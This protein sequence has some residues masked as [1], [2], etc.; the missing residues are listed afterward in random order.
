MHKSFTNCTI[1]SVLLEL[2]IYFVGRTMYAWD[3]NWV[4][5]LAWSSVSYEAMLDV[6]EKDFN[7]YVA[8]YS[9]SK[10]RKIPDTARARGRDSRGDFGTETRAVNYLR[11]FVDE[12]SR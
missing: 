10:A 6:A 2:T 5:K 4:L 9:R 11:E 3:W 12:T 8:Y 7:V 1:N